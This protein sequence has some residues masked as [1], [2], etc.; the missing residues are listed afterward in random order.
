[1]GVVRLQEKWRWAGEGLIWNT[2]GEAFKSGLLWLKCNIFAKIETKLAGN[3][4]VLL[5][6]KRFGIEWFAEEAKKLLLQFSYLLT[7]LQK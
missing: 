1:M 7:E 4:T 3:N 6:I 2:N 5:R